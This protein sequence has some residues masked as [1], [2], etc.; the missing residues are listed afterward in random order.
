MPAGHAP[1]AIVNITG[2][3]VVRMLLRSP[4]HG[5]VSGRLALITVTG[6]KSGSRFTFPVGYSQDGDVVKIRVGWPE[7]KLWWRNLRGGGAPVTMWLKGVER[8]G[9]GETHQD[10]TG[11]TWIDVRLDPPGA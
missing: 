3:R 1:F 5:L 2:N 6:R 7:R 10:E 11:N 4:A 8:S 9:H